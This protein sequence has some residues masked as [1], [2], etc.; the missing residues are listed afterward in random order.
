MKGNSRS[1]QLGSQREVENRLAEQLVLQ[2]GIDHHRFPKAV[3]L[4]V[5]QVA[6]VVDPLRPLRGNLPLGSGFVGSG[7]HL[8]LQSRPPSQ[9]RLQLSRRT[10]HP[11]LRGP[12]SRAVG[13]NGRR[14]MQ[15]PWASVEG[16]G[17]RYLSLYCND[18][19]ATHL[20]KWPAGGSWNS[21][22]VD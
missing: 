1:A 2:L 19:T 10:R 14:P 22:S 4:G 6:D 3:E 8:A 5:G 16:P 15:G 13:G 11:A 12:L 17:R 9:K 18:L 20:R 7:K 21:G